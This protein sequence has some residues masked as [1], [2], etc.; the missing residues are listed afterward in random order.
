MPKITSQWWMEDLEKCSK[1]PDS[2]G[3]PCEKCLEEHEPAI[4]VELT[5]MDRD[6]FNER[7]G[8]PLTDLF[9]PKDLWWLA[10]RVVG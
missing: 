10:G 1:H 2:P 6:S 8:R 4:R 3:L 5:E 9:P 7:P